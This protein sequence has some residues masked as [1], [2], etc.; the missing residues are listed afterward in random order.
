[1]D[2]EQ[3]EILAQEYFELDEPVPYK[4]FLIRPAKIRDYYKFYK[5]IE[6]LTLN[7]N[8][9]PKGIALS[10]LGYLIKQIDENPDKKYDIRFSYIVEICLGVKSGLFCPICGNRVTSEAISQ[11]TKVFSELKTDKNFDKWYDANFINC[12]KCDG[13]LQDVIRYGFNEKNQPCV[14]IENSIVTKE[15]FEAIRTII[16]HQNMP[17]YDD[18]YIDPDLEQDLK[19]I[20]EIQNRNI[21]TPTLE[22]QMTCILASGCGYTF[23]TLKEMTLRKFVLLLQKIDKKLHYQIYKTHE[24]SGA[25]TLKGGLD[26]WIYEKRK[27][28]FEN[29]IPLDNLKQKFQPVSKQ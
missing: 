26:H 19:A 14:E 7:K 8:K 15:D 16:C 22:K 1:M 6:S 29:I 24:V 20:E 21:V 12:E 17:D 25:I 11:K 4:D 5:G 27:N 13:K 9:D 10:H 18:S 28:K 23:E 2:R 3:I